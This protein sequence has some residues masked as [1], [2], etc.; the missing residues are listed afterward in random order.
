MKTVGKVVFM[1]FTEDI[2]TLVVAL[3]TILLY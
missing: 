1:C 3:N 2:I